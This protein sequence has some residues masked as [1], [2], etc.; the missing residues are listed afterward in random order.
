[1]KEAVLVLGGTGGIGE[2]L[3]RRLAARGARVG[4]AAR[5]S[6]PVDALAAETGAT[7]FV[8]DARQPDVVLSVARA[9]AAGPGG[10]TG[11]VNCVGSLLLK[12]AHQTTPAEWDEVMAQNL[13]TAFATV[14][15][16]AET[17]TGGGSVVLLSS[18]AARVGLANHEAIAAAKAGIIGLAQS[19]AATYAPRGIRVNVVAPGLVRTPLTG[20]LTSAEAVLKSSAA[21]H[22]LGRIGEPADV[23]QAIAWLLSPEAAWITGQVIGVDG[24]LGTVRARR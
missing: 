17:M 10:L 15:A 16:A 19:A 1:M 8:L 6:G 2:V 18:A 21:M 24:G 9:F 12:P 11:M 20:F 4:I 14:A 13:R 22:P 7:G 3:V 5:T 23:A